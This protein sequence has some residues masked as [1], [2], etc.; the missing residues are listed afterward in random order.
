MMLNHIGQTDVAEKIQNAWL[1]TIEQGIHTVDIY[2]PKSSK[3]KVGTNEFAQAVISNLG[4]KPS[5]FKSVEYANSQPLKLP[6]YQPKQPAK[7]ELKGVDI[8]IHWKGENAN[9]LAEKVKRIECDEVKLSM[10]TNRGIKVWPEGFE[11]TF[12]TDHWRC[13]FKQTNGST[14]EKQVIIELLSNAMKEKLDTIKTENLYSFDGK[15]AYSLGQ[16]Q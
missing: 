6:K 13:R 2:N 16:G 5:V 11:E 3:Q 9:E 12:C 15:D 4:K 1:L 8:F 7:K 14:I 10:I